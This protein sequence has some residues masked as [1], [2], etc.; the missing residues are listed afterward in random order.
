[1]LCGLIVAPCETWWHQRVLESLRM[2]QVAGYSCELL[3]VWWSQCDSSICL[4]LSTSPIQFSLLWLSPVNDSKMFQEVLMTI[5]N[6]KKGSEEA[7]PG[8]DESEAVT[9]RRGQIYSEI[10]QTDCCWKL[11]FCLDPKPTWSLNWYDTFTWKKSGICHH[12]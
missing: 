8:E 5:A 11:N 3:S 7:E 2:I 12:F 4:I 6:G 1:M 10:L 9:C